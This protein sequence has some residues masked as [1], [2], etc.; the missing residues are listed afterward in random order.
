MDAK[1]VGVPLDWPWFVGGAYIVKSPFVKYQS[2][3]GISPSIF[4]TGMFVFDVFMISSVSLAM[5]LTFKAFGY[6][7]NQWLM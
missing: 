2:L 1:K 4:W 3:T 7:V 6:S 5:A